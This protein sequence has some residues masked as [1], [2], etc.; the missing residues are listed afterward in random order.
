MEILIAIMVMGIGLI[1]VI[2]LFPISV[3]RSAQA[4]NLTNATA[5]RYNAEAQLD[6]TRNIVHLPNFSNPPVFPYNQLVPVIPGNFE[7]AF[8]FQGGVFSGRY[9]VDPLGAYTYA[10]ESPNNTYSFGGILPV[11]GLYRFE[12]NLLVGNLAG[13]QALCSLPDSFIHQTDGVVTAVAGAN[14]T[15]D[16]TADLSGVPFGLGVSRI[17]AI[18]ITGKFSFTRDITGIAGQTITM[19]SALPAG[20][21]ATNAKIEAYEQG[22]YT[23]LLGV[24]KD[25]LGKAQVDVVVFFR[26]SFLP[27]EEIAL[28][29]AEDLVFDPGGRT[30]QVDA[31]NYITAGV[32]ERFWRK[33]GFLFDVGNVRWYRIQEIVDNTTGLPANT[34]RIRLEDK[35]VEPIV[36]AAF[37]KNIVDVYPIGAKQ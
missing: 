13:A 37:L 35:P 27:A 22:R 10:T 15:M 36:A 1:S 26:R 28:A 31:T 3:L 29:V 5:L 2:T 23:Y 20:F 33:G 17:I 16:N 11:P 8:W 34:I 7:S 25:A 4:T 30:Y 12:A 24:R 19:S 6:V 32:N 18:D 14:L 21:T 9:L